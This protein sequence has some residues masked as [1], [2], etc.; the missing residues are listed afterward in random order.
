MAADIRKRLAC[1]DEENSWTGGCAAWLD[2]EE[3]Q[4]EIRSSL[5]SSSAAASLHVCQQPF[6]GVTVAGTTQQLG[7]PLPTGT[8]RTQLFSKSPILAD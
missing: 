4:E 1:L 3:T 2:L 5:A 6:E 7:S 8:R